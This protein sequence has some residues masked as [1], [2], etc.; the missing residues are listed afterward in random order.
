MSKNYKNNNVQMDAVEGLWERWFISESDFSASY[1][2]LMLLLPA[3]FVDVADIKP[4]NAV[5][6]NRC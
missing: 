2:V 4:L 6:P 5:G 3:S 1:S